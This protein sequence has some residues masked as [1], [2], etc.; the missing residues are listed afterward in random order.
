MNIYTRLEAF[1]LD[2]MSAEAPQIN[3]MAVLWQSKHNDKP[4]VVLVGPGT[5]I[6]K[7]NNLTV[8]GM[9][10]VIE[11]LLLPDVVIL[12]KEHLVL[13]TNK[14]PTS[15]LNLLKALPF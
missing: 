3:K 9:K 1:P 13:H 2:P 6:S 12:G 8:S 15:K 14:K 7:G 11:D 4:S 5:K 10:L